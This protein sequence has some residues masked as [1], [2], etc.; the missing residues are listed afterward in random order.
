MSKYDDAPDQDHSNIQRVEELAQKK[1]VS[2][3]EI[4]LA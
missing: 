3:F 1:R 2:M 4:S